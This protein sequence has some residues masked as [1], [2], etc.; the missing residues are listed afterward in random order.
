MRSR[1]NLPIYLSY[2]MVCL[3]V[4]GFIVRGLQFSVPWSHPYRVTAT[5]AD[6]D[7]LLPNNE[8]F[9][10]GTKVGYVGGV[11]VVGGHAQVQLVFDNG[12][13]LP[14]H[15]DATAQVRKKNLLGETYVDLTRGAQPGQ[16]Q[17]GGVIPLAHTV[18]ITEIDQVLAVFDPATVQRVQ[19]LIN[20]IGEGTTNNG[21]NMNSQATSLNQ[22][23]T[24][25][26]VPATR[27][28]VRKQQVNDIVLELQ[29]FYTVLANQREQVRQEFG[30]W[31]AVM[32][33]LAN[34]ETAIGGT[35]RQAD[36]LLQ[37]LDVLV[38][39]NVGNLRTT[40]DTLP[41]TLTSLNKFLDQSN[42]ILDSISTVR[43]SIHDVFP[44]LGSSFFDTDPNNNNQ[45]FWS[46]FSVNCSSACTGQA[47]TPAPNSSA[48]NASWAAAM[49]G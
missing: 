42:G 31:T 49:G 24:V 27:L 18:P 15:P 21:D 36:T 33:Q 2:L 6:A 11:S 13:A 29:K 7:S 4:L 48:P 28:S 9:L 30:T 45:H 32:Q 41:G 1:W 38:N 25:L 23:V 39:G 8:V 35:V 3:L 19:L 46:V 34:Q 12:N 16:I 47:S 43:G 5:F 40:L 26:N 37:N 44:N 10:N 17:S 14:L 20:A 22:L